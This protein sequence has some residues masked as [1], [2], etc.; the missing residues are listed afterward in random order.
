MTIGLPSVGALQWPYYVAMEKGWYTDARIDLE[1]VIIANPAQGVQGLVSG[2]LGIYGGSPDPVI[3]AIAEANA[4]LV[5]TGGTTDRPLYAL[6]VQPEIRAYEDL[7]GKRVGVFSETSMSGTWL[8]MMLKSHGLNRGDY[9]L[10][11]VG[12][13][14]AVYAALQSKGISAGMLTQPQD[15]Q[16]LRLG[17]RSLGLSTEV[18][19]EIAWGS[20]STS[21]DFATKNEEVLVRFLSV[22]RRASI[23]VNDP[24]NRTEAVA[25]LVKYTKA[26]QSDAEQTYD[27]WSENKALTPD[28]SESPA[29][30]KSMIDMMVL[31]N[32]LKELIAVEKVFDPSYMEK[33]KAR[34]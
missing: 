16:A 28:S 2:S 8:Q 6:I 32:Q 13:T 20:Y 25:I 26:A 15:L 3:K 1:Q 12:G 10:I 30:I 22:Q 21:R 9:E 18:V 7:R 11:P 14:A 34:G 27:L 4:P 24:K 29:A 23:W 19:K 17:Y 31:T 5:I 33:A